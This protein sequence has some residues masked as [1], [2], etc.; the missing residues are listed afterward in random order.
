MNCH[1]F[2]NLYKL[3][4]VPIRYWNFIRNVPPVWTLNVRTLAF[5]SLTVSA[6]L[7]IMT[8][9][10][11]IFIHRNTYLGKVRTLQVSWLNRYKYWSDSRR[12]VLCALLVFSHQWSVRIIDFKFSI[13][14]ASSSNGEHTYFHVPIHERILIACIRAQIF[15]I[16]TLI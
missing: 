6:E 3:L 15:R 10:G 1:K 5:V 11:I 16:G 9:I 7:I 8:F 4:Y 14:M 12:V 13:E 2:L